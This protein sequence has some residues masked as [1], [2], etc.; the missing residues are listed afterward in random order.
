MDLEAASHVVLYFHRRRDGALLFL[1]LISLYHDLIPS[2]PF[3]VFTYH[4][5]GHHFIT[6][7]ENADPGIWESLFHMYKEC[8][9]ILC[10][11]LAINTEFPQYSKA[12]ITLCEK[13]VM[14]LWQICNGDP[15]R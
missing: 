6:T 5:L 9:D 7:L 4:S 12:D 14:F 11:W 1:I 8:F 2:P 13:V 10:N 3:Q 15:W